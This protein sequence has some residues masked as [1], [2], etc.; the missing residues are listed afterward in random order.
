MYSKTS[1]GIHL[2]IT[3]QVGAHT[4]WIACVRNWLQP[5]FGYICGESNL[6]AHEYYHA[7]SHAKIKPALT[8]ASELVWEHT[9]V[10]ERTTRRSLSFYENLH[11]SVNRFAVACELRPARARTEAHTCSRH[12]YTCEC[13]SVYYTRM[14]A[15]ITRAIAGKNLENSNIGGVRVI[16]FKVRLLML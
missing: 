9:R 8:S 4:Q 15:F 10:D 13:S 12:Y 7:T 5:L 2:H 11:V 16:N 3:A 14:Y 1:I 6:Y